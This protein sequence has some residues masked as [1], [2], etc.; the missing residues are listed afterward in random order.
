MR[1]SVPVSSNGAGHPEGYDEWA[2]TNV[3]RQRQPGYAVA[4][5]TLPLGDLTSEQMR[6]LADIARRYVGDT[7][8]TT[9]EQNIVLRW[10]AEG[11]LPDLYAELKA[12]GLA[13]PGAGTI[14]DVT[15]C[16]GTDTCKLGIASSRGLAGELRT[17]LAARQFELDE[18]VR[19]L[20]IKVTGCFNSCGQHHVADIGFYGNSRNVGGVTVPHFQVMLGGQWRENA[21]SYGLAIGAVPSKRIP[22]VVDVITTRYVAEREADE[23]FQ[24]FIARIGKKELKAMV[25][26][27]TT[28]PPHDEDPGYYTDWGDPRVFTM[29]DMGIGECAGEVISKTELEL[30]QAESIAFDAQVALEEGDLARAD[31]RAYA[32]MVAGARALV[33]TENPNVPDDSDAIVGEFRERFYD[34]ERFFDRFAKGRFARPLFD[35]HAAA[36]DAHE[37]EA[38]RVLVEE[39]QLFIDAVHAFEIREAGAQSALV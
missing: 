24:D 25:D 11:D 19:D 32:A 35:R 5:V 31:E 16:P 3:Y 36:P 15:A 30:T 20:R 14:V 10:V 33:R 13:E 17:R 8:R 7:V 21:G 23:T 6:R 34:T 22:E 9:V 18:A 26:E 39:A 29:G 4:T 1:E 37:E 27:L 38:T 2:Q 12:I 28:V